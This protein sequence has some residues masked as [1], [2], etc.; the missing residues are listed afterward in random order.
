[1]YIP[2]GTETLLRIN[3]LEPRPDFNQIGE[4]QLA[5]DDE[6]YAHFQNDPTIEVIEEVM[7]FSRLNSVDHPHI[8][9][10][11]EMEVSE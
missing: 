5:V 2:D 1:M 7:V 8:I 9:P 3:V 4:H 10:S 6:T 11:N